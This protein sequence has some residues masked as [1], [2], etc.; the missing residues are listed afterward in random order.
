M[1]VSF[2]SSQ[3]SWDRLQ[4]CR[5]ITDTKGRMFIL[6]LTRLLN[7]MKLWSIPGADQRQWLN[8]Q[9]FLIVHKPCK[10]WKYT[11][12]GTLS[13]PFHHVLTEDS[14]VAAFLSSAHAL[15]RHTDRGRRT[16]LTDTNI[17]IDWEWTG[18]HLPAIF[19]EHTAP[20][21]PAAPGRH[22]VLPVYFFSTLLPT[23]TWSNKWGN[24]GTSVSV[25]FN[26]LKLTYH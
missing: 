19:C 24:Q 13:A 16:C 21:A 17:D 8:K 7:V 26:H 18:S 20:A 11:R 3:D 4:Q 23:S 2:F 10:L 6:T 25:L 5:F 15:N 12:N 9:L 14:R 22:G 1:R